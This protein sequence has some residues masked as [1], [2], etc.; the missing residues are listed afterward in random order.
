MGVGATAFPI[1]CHVKKKRNGKANVTICNKA[2]AICKCNKAFPTFPYVFPNVFSNKIYI[3][4]YQKSK[5]KKLLFDLF[6]F[7]Q[8]FTLCQLSSSFYLA[9]IF[10]DKIFYFVF[11]ESTLLQCLKKIQ[12]QVVVFNKKALVKLS[13]IFN[14]KN[15]PL[16]LGKFHDELFLVGMSR[17]VD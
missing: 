17:I 14:S 1:T 8:R 10:F 16:N 2:N 3:F 6:D 7:L 4:L 9:C 11:K 15:P 12:V 13:G 5:R